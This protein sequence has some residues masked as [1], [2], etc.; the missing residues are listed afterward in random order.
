MISVNQLTV[1]FSGIDLFKNLTCLITNNDKIGLV[2]KNGA[3]KSTFFKVLIKMI[4]PDEGTVSYSDDIKIG[5]LPQQLTNNSKMSV[6]DEAMTAF[7]ELNQYKKKIDKLNKQIQERTDYESEEY[8]NIIQEFTEVSDRY[9]MFGGG[10]MTGEVEK[11]LLGLGFERTDFIRPLSEFSGGWK[12]RVELAKILLKRP[13]IF[14][15]DEPT[16]HLD[17]ES[18]QWLEDF[19]KDYNGAV[20]LIS[21]DRA[22]LDNI[23]KRTLEI[24]LG[25]LYDYRVPY[26]QFVSLRAER[27]TQQLAAYENQ[28]KYI[29]DTEKFIERFRYQAT[30]AVQVQSRI[31]QLDKVERIEIDDEDNSSIAFRF[32]PAPRSGQLVVHA[33]HMSKAYGEKLILSDVDFELERGQ[34]VAFVGR[35][36][37]GKSTFSK[38]IIGEIPYDGDVKIGHNV[39]I[40]YFAQNQD[41]LLNMNATVLET[42]DQI[43]VGD[44]RKRL[45]DILGS[46]LF[47]GEDVD[48]KVSVL[49]GGERNR[50]A[51][52]KLLLEPYNLLI[53]DEPTNHLDIRSKDILKQA[54][55]SY[56]GTL[57]IVSHDRDFLNGLTDAIYEF[58]DKKIKQHLCG[59]TEFLEK[60][61]LQSLSQIEEKAPILIEVEKPVRINKVSSKEIYELKKNL[62]K[63][64]RKVER[65]IQDVESNIE[66][67]E[68]EMSQLQQSLANTGE[69]MNEDMFK[70]HSQLEKL[71]DENVQ[72]WDALH[73]ELENK[74]KEKSDLLG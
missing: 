39:K 15:L 4:A 54:L 67:Y 18:V 64:I 12:M 70:K 5:Y 21:H 46:F 22:F 57:I 52:A 38:V 9:N 19:L 60:R 44:V 69:T 17:I 42:L 1:R 32:P 68:A 13:D 34:K 14:L 16:N 56:D 3:G 29:E 55:L 59:I 47:K 2:G 28:Q 30:K 11:T 20:L 72:K 73:L 6:F 36:G 43:A 41:E 51:L 37:E 50:L 31:K 71:I 23:T 65:A 53:L 58:R 8:M 7:S 45:R 63:E 26:S 66:K 25:S 10:D 24:S 74:E 27:R 40:G 35:N 33:Q 62:D 61:K 49:S 48:K